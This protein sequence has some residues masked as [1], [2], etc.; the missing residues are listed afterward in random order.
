LKDTYQDGNTFFTD[1]ENGQIAS[2]TD[3]RLEVIGKDQLPSWMKGK[4]IHE[5][6]QLTSSQWNTYSKDNLLFD[7]I[8]SNGESPE[9]V[10]QVFRDLSNNIFGREFTMT[11][12]L[13]DRT[14]YDGTHHGIDFSSPAGYPVKS[15]IGGVTTLVQNEAGNY[16]IGVRSDD[17]NLWI[18]GHLGSYSV[19]LNQRVEAGRQLGVVFN[20][21]YFRSV[22][23]DY[24][25]PHTHLEVH[26]GK[27]YNQGN[28][29]SPLQAYWEF[30]N[31]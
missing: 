5:L 29:I 15:V 6:G 3:G 9:P 19:P 21:G 25:A 27:V 8:S 13:F 31:R 26:R 18:Y 28:V 11:A 10:K 23:F 2:H 12:G 20:G 4:Y 30:R 1:F 7:R 22:G 16:F 24:M 14:Q 17:G